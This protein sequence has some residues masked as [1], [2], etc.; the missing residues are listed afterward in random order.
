MLFASAKTSPYPPRENLRAHQKLQ[1]S[2]V[3]NEIYLHVVPH[4]YNSQ[5]LKMIDDYFPD[6]QQELLQDHFDKVFDNVFEAFKVNSLRTFSHYE[7]KFF[8]N[9]YS[10]Q[11]QEMQDFVKLQI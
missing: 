5:F 10:R 6:K 7:V 1:Q 9:W 3:D 4:S 2:S 11:N 8:A